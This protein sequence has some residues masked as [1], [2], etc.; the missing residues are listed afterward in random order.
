[1]ENAPKRNSGGP[2]QNFAI[3]KCGFLVNVKKWELWTGL[4]CFT[5]MNVRK[6]WENNASDYLGGS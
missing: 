2:I 4:S 3:R 5:H 6:T 1:M